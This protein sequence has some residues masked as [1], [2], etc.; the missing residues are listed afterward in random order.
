MNTAADPF[1]SRRLRVRGR[2]QGVGYRYACVRQ[3]HVLGLTGWVRNRIDGSVELLLQGAPA[4]VDEM[5]AWLHHGVP[6]ARVATVD[7]EA[8]ASPRLAAFERR[9]DL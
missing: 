8:D 1:E 9:P 5:T 7:A 6:G 4:T 2:V 3:A